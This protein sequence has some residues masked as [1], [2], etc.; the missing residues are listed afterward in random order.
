MIE[1]LTNDSSSF[2]KTCPY[3]TRIKERCPKK[4]KPIKINGPAEK[5]LK[6]KISVRVLSLTIP[7][8]VPLVVIS[9]LLERL[10]FSTINYVK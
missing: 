1:R 5:I 9:F 7:K 8:R 4:L 3:R 2:S 6:T 10:S